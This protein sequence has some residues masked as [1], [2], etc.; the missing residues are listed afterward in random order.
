MANLTFVYGAF[1][2]AGA[3]PDIAAAAQTRVTDRSKAKRSMDI[4]SFIV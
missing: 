2:A 3:G 4:D 1:G